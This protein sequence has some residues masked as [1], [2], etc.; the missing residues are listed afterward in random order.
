MRSW[1]ALATVEGPQLRELLAE[2]GVQLTLLR[3]GLEP[4]LG[5]PA[6]VADL[7]A[8]PLGT[9]QRRVHDQLV[10]EPLGPQPGQ[11]CVALGEEHPKPPRVLEREAGVLPD[12][13][14]PEVG[15]AVAGVRRHIVKEHDP[16]GR[17]LG[18]PALEVVLDRLEGVQP[19]DVQQVQ[20]PVLHTRQRVTE[21]HLVQRDRLPREVLPNHPLHRLEHLRTVPPRVV[22]ALEGVHPDQLGPGHPTVLHRL[23]E[24]KK[25]RPPVHPQ[26]ADPR[27][28]H[29]PNQIV[30]EPPVTAPRPHRVHRAHLV[31]REHGLPVFP[32]SLS[33]RG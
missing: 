7:V 20:A 25:A 33:Q 14:V 2:L 8:R 3:D 15:R 23:R 32:R 30:R 22:L 1:A 6:Q 17:E 29:P 21:E 24:R 4:L 11:A 19:V 18:Q 28:T 26:L 31:R 9:G 27:R 13:L 12:E 10:V 5:H 16:L